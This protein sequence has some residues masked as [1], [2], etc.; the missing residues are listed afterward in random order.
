MAE[1][2]IRLLTRADDAGSCHSANRAIVETF[3][4]Q[5]GTT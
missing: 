4:T 3:R 5:S 1:A 2:R